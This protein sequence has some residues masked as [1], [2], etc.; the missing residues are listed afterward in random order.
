MRKHWLWFVRGLPFGLANI[1]PGISGGTVALVLGYYDE[2][3]AAVKGLRFAALVPWVLG[4]GA[5]ILGGSWLILSLLE[6][7]TTSVYAVMLGFIFASAAL[8]ARHSDLRERRQL[9][10][11][12][13]LGAAGAWL[14][15]GTRLTAPMAEPS[16]ISLFFVGVAASSAMI[17]PGISGAA[18]FLIFGYYQPILEAVTQLDFTVLVPTGAGVVAGVLLLAHIMNFLLRQWPHLTYALLSGLILG[19][20]R[21]VLVEPTVW[22]GILFAVG[23]AAALR[24]GPVKL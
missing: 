4:I 23:F 1:L 20:T 6:R 16:M 12:V 17:V 18:V 15:A 19:S 21:M 3:V 8:V 5:S 10:A 22:H 11:F 9:W 7:H 2:V 14:F 24:L 13:A